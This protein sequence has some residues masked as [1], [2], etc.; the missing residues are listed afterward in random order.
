M[1]IWRKSHTPRGCTSPW[2]SFVPSNCRHESIGRRET[3]KHDKNDDR[4]RAR[5]KLVFSSISIT[6][7]ILAARPI[8]NIAKSGVGSGDSSRHAI[9]FEESDQY[10]A[11]E[12]AQS[13]QAL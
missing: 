11:N 8:P 7:S 9:N 13:E 4:E 12:Q 6:P 3:G 1:F 10:E 5:M 2:A